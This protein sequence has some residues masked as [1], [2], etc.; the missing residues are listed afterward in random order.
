TIDTWMNL[1]HSCSPT[2]QSC[3]PAVILV[4]THLDKIPEEEVPAKRVKSGT[5]TMMYETVDWTLPSTST[6]ADTA[7]DCL[8]MMD[9][10]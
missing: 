3:I 4:G 9:K 1:I 2:P 6:H 10:L 5:H 8:V 7:K